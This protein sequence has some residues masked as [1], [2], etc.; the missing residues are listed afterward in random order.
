MYEVKTEDVYQDFRSNKEMF[1]LS[2]HSA[3]S[4]YLDDSNKLVTGNSVVLQ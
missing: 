2:N 1:D 4:K 3:K